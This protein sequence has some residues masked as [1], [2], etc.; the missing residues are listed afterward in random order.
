M[1]AN[2]AYALSIQHSHMP[3]LAVFWSGRLRLLNLQWSFS[4]SL[5]LLE[6]SLAHWASVPPV[7]TTGGGR[8]T[9][10]LHWADG[11]LYR[12]QGAL[13]SALIG[14]S[15]RFI[16]PCGRSLLPSLVHWASMAPLSRKAGGGIPPSL[17]FRSAFI[18]LSSP[19]S[20]SLPLLIRSE[21]SLAHWA[22]SSPSSVTDGGDALPHWRR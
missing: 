9:P 22:D 15:V 13:A 2:L 5:P 6:N 3:S 4:S 1:V 17:G 14:L 18:P 12:P 19:W 11:S 8:T 20:F 16:P 21:N 7:S 10:L